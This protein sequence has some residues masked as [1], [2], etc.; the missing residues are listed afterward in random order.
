VVDFKNWTF[1]GVMISYDHSMGLAGKT[2]S[3]SQAVKSRQ[4]S[5]IK[6]MN[7]L[8]IFVLYTLLAPFEWL[9]G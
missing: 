7:N 4:T 2:S 8:F 5:T 6:G 3:L 9:N 1:A